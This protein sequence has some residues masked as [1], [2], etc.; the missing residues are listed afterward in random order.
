MAPALQT[1][2]APLAS[3][4]RDW[5]SDSGDA[6]YNVRRMDPRVPLDPPRPP[7]GTRRPG[8]ALQ[9]SA[10]RTA[11]GLPRQGIRPSAPADPGLRRHAAAL[12]RVNHAGEIAA[13][14][15]YHGQALTARCAGNARRPAPRPAARKAIT[16]P[17]AGSAST[18]SGPTEPAQSA[19]VRGLV[20]DRR[21]RRPG[22][23]PRQPRLRGGNRAPG[24]RSPRGHLQRCPQTTR[25]VAAIIQ[26]MRRTRRP[27]SQRAIAARCRNAAGAGAATDAP[28]RTDHDAHGV[29][30]LT[31]GPQLCLRCG[32][33]L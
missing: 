24:R 32:A 29:L 22:R 11:A 6:L 3:P 28:D 17:G 31:D 33:C 18:N 21:A 10:A 20:R 26:Q 9:L 1:A 23:R 25:A 30:D 12:M 13:Q 14:A 5:G 27:R 2:S 4:C 19:V 8:L 7:A 15:L 16:W